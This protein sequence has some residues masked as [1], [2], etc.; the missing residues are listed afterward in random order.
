[1]R[2]PVVKEEKTK[3]MVD[4]AAFIECLDYPNP[5][6]QVTA[7]IQIVKGNISNAEVVSKLIELSKCRNE[8]I[9]K[10]FG[11]DTIGH[12]SIGAL[13]VLNTYESTRAF[14]DIMS[15]LEEGEQNII[16]RI[17]RNFNM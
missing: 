3:N 6:V 1:M 15:E 2:V 9:H 13:Q 11:K 8:E 7:L 5:K 10:V 17:V 16:K 14:E 12:Y 4:E